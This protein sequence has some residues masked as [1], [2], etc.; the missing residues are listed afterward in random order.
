MVELMGT[1][2]YGTNIAQVWDGL[3]KLG[4]YARPKFVASRSFHE[5]HA[6]A[7]LFVAFGSD[8]LG[9]ATCFV[10]ESSGTAEIWDSQGG[11]SFQDQDQLASYWLG[12]AIEIYEAAP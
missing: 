2:A 4:L 5:L 11:K 8:P 10:R 6:P 3:R 7:V 12:Y 9:H 1:T